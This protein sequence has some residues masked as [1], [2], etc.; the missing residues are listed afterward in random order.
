MRPGREGGISQ[1]E[2]MAGPAEWAAAGG[3]AGKGGGQGAEGRLRAEV[4]LGAL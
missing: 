4:A 2:A 3:E 1:G